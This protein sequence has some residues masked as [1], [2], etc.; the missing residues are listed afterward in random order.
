MWVREYCGGARGYC[1][2]RV[3]VCRCDPHLRE[4]IPETARPYLPSFYACYLWLCIVLS[5]YGGVAIRYY[6]QCT[7]AFD[8]TFSHEFTPLL[9]AVG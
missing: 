1:D 4:H 2:E 7:S 8:V 3:C 9:R 6:I 5:S